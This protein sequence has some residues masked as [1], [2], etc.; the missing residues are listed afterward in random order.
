M[1]YARIVVPVALVLVIALL[2]ACGGGPDPLEFEDRDLVRGMDG[3]EPETEGC[4]WVRLRWVEVSGGPEEARRGVAAWI[5]A[6]MFE[7]L[8]D[9]WTVESAE[10]VAD[11]LF[12]DRAEFAAE[13]PDAA[14]TGWYLERTLR[15]LAA[16]EGSISLE[17][18]ERRY[19][20]GAHGMESVRLVTL[21]AATGEVVGIEDLV[22]EA[23]LDA[24]ADAVARA[25]RAS[26]DLAAD[27]D[28][29]EAGFWVEDGALPRT[30]NVAR[31]D[32]G[33]RVHYDAYEI[34]PYAMGPTD[35]TVPWE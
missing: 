4:S 6:R 21:D 33:L 25:V 35:V 10:D 11:A 18:S 20:G 1:S 22:G 14:T 24:F 30:D 2:S 7:P 5:E 32:G 19:T 16:P 15:P 17:Y 23:D 3:C 29:A 27:A 12:A 34:G 8:G 28:L 31:V 13:F 9:H 26:R